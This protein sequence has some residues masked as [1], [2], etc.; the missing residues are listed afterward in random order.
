MT[1]YEEP[2]VYNLGAD[3]IVAGDPA[4]M[5]TKALG[6]YPAD[7]PEPDVYDLDAGSTANAS[8]QLKN[9]YV[10]LVCEEVAF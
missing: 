3:D 4:V 6:V 5:E 7:I 8:P 2:A 9:V 10:P 1:A